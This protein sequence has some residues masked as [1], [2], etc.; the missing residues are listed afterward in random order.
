MTGPGRNRMK[1]KEA[2]ER[3]PFSKTGRPDRELV[4]AC[5]EGDSSAWELLIVR[6]QRLIY[7]IAVKMGLPS[8]DAADVFQ[9]ICLRLVEKLPT[10]R[11]HEKLS[12]WI[13]TSTRRECW[14]VAAAARRLHGADLDGMKEMQEVAA[15]GSL[16]DDNHLVLQQQQIL[17]DAVDALPD[18]C[19]ELITLLF[20]KKDEFKYSDIARR[21]NM[22]A[23]SVGPNRAR[24]LDK[25]RKL[26]DGKI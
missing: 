12:S 11:N 16:A 13:I 4:A 5:L 2:A 18:R 15:P 3:K 9:S 17:R 21:L 24:C 20:Y 6:Y 26:L 7:S 22:S 23:A 19:R 1:V 8:D 25:L 14:R 10:L